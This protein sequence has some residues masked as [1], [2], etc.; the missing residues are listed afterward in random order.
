MVY[1]ALK[2]KNLYDN[3]IF[4]CGMFNFS[5]KLQGYLYTQTLNEPESLA[6]KSIILG[7]PQSSMLFYTKL[8]KHKSL[9]HYYS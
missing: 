7:F 8:F 5:E 1:F 3:Y 6:K 2:C 4:T 9:T